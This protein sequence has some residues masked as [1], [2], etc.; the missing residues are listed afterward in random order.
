M[1]NKIQRVTDEFMKQDGITYVSLSHN[2]D[3]NVDKLY[4]YVCIRVSL[5][6]SHYIGI[7]G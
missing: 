5:V 6:I 7:P 1:V 2:N 3:A 4:T